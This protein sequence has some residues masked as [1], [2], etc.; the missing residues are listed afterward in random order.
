MWSV[1]A[2]LAAGFAT[3]ATDLGV[4]V[5]T[6]LVTLGVTGGQTCTDVSVV[7]AIAVKTLCVRPASLVVTA[8]AVA[9]VCALV[10]GAAV[11]AGLSRRHGPAGSPPMRRRLTGR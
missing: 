1:L 2:G 9:L 11:H 4:G 3:I 10:V 5:W 8:W 6:W 7:D